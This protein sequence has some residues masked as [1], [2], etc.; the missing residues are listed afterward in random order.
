MLIKVV[1]KNRL[2]KGDNDL[3]F[4][5]SKSSTERIDAME[6]LRRQFYG[7]PKR[8]QRVIRIIKQA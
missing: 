7:K 3:A 8:L 6:I 2:A 4:W 5:L 1:R